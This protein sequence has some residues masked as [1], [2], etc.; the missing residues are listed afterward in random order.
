[1]GD[2]VIAEC[3]QKVNDILLH[4]DLLLLLILFLLHIS[5]SLIQMGRCY[6]RSNR[7][8]L[9]SASGLMA[10][11]LIL[12]TSPYHNNLMNQKETLDLMHS[13]D[14]PHMDCRMSL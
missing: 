4:L 10:D 1:M 12:R 8:M 3:R 9:M 5:L 14:G 6:L 11:F 7:G 13:L 2:R